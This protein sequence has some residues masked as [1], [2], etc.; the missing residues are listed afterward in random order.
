MLVE[1]QT[2]ETTWSASNREWYENLGYVFTKI[3]DKLIVKSTDI[4]HGS[5]IRILVECDN[6]KKEKK[7][8]AQDYYRKTNDG[9][10]KYYCYECISKRKEENGIYKNKLQE[11]FDKFILYCNKNGYIPISKVNNLSNAHSVLEFMC[12]K[13]G[14]CERTWNSI[15]NAVRKGTPMCQ[16]CAEESRINQRKNNTTY[17]RHM[18]ESINN[19]K[20]INANEYI[21]NNKRNLKILCGNC[22]KREFITSL[23][24]YVKGKNKCD[25]C[26][27]SQSNG[28]RTISHILLKYNVNYISEKR[29]KDCRDKRPLPFDFYLPDYNCCIEYDGEQHFRQCFTKS[30]FESTKKHDKIKNEYCKNNKIT[31]VRI[32]YLDFNNLE[33][34]LIKEL[35]LQPKQAHNKIKYISTSQRKPA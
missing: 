29:F 5:G 31:L 15:S 21:N 27:R 26:A 30:S 16:K 8:R 1:N 24:A 25:Y 6:C 33:E 32:S 10:K 3:R 19:N 7:L 4:K 9:T 2:V 11:L 12:S 20:L 17:V 34:I 22:G 18:I 23:D 28:E 14:K 35:N 13:H